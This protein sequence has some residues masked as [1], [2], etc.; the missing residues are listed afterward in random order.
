[1]LKLSVNVTTI[2]RFV[3]LLLELFYNIKHFPLSGIYNL[4][5]A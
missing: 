1:M 5:T 2:K 4:V 3:D